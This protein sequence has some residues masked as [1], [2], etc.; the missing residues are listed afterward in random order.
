M[1]VSDK[2]H[3][4]GHT[5]IE[6][7]IAITLGML[8]VAGLATVFAQNSQARYEIE[9]ANQQTENG[10]YAMQLLT[11]D[12]RNAGYLAEFDPSVLPTP[13]TKP[14]PCLTTLAA[15]NT[16]LPISVQGYDNGASAPSCLSDVRTGT[17]IVV[18]R[19]ASTCAVGDTGCDAVISGNVVPYF[20][21]SACNS[22]TELSSLTANGGDF[23]LLSTA[24]TGSPDFTTVNVRRQNKDCLSSAP[25][26]QYRVHIYFIANND[27]S[28]DGIPTLKRAELGKLPGGT[29]GF[30][31]VPLVEGIE[32]LQIEYGVDTAAPS[33]GAPAVFT[34]NPD[35]YPAA[36]PCAPATCVGYW[37]NTVAAKINMLVRSTTATWGYSDYKTYTLGL[38]ADGT[39]N[40]FG[41]F[42]DGYKR[43]VFTSVVRL[44]N[45]SGRNAP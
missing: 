12:L 1:T 23:Y 28:G 21:A 29:L 45:T 39:A 6:M 41:P 24:S 38:K 43:H 14:D 16:A 11:D 44:N 31:I 2:I 15:L 27:Q 33:T 40:A 37:R 5:I 35:S 10:R 17:D 42:P 4:G 20:Q 18:V 30:N 32:N 3:Q 26:Q 22:A 25:Y 34:A 9:R 19:R 7:M 8:I 13:A 36:T